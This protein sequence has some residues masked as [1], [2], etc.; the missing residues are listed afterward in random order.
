[1]VDSDTPVALLVMVALF[2]ALPLI[3]W[4]SGRLRMP[5]T[6]ATVAVGVVASALPVGREIVGLAPDLARQPVAA[7]AGL[8]GSLP[9]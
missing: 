3:A 6:V 7:W 2:A 5:Y 1:M 9:A 4:L 8:R